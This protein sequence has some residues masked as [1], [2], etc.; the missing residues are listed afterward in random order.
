MPPDTAAQPVARSHKMGKWLFFLI[1]ATVAVSAIFVTFSGG[2]SG[3]VRVLVRD[4]SGA[5]AV[6]TVSLPSGALQAVPEVDANSITTL[7]SRLFRQSDGSV[8]TLDDAG[9]VRRQGSS[10]GQLSVLIASPTP[11]V[12]RTPLAVWGDGAR[13]A[14]VSPS[15]GSVQVFGLTERGAY[16]PLYVHTSLNANSLG[17]TD[18]GSVLV[19]AKYVGETTELYGVVLATG[20]LSRITTIEGLA[21]LV[22]NI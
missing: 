3:S 1:T 17:F 15:D 9:I 20:A 22:P 16:T 11:P 8:I 19:M 12:L 4:V 5:R 14:W 13:I 21:S 18:D 6:H 2:I 7:S 10:T